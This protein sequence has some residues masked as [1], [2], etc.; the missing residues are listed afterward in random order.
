M[1]ST[2]PWQLHCDWLWDRCGSGNAPKEPRI[3]IAGCGTFEPYAFGLANPRA[4]ILATDISRRSLAIAQRRCQLHGVRNTRMAPCDLEHPETW[5]KGQF[6][7]IECYGVLMNLSDPE[8]TLRELGKRLTSRGVL[9]IMVYPWFSRARIFQIQR[10]ARLCG[11]HANDQSHPGQL[12]SLM[13]SLP[14]AHPLRWAF[15][16]YRDSRNDAGVVDAFLHA[17]DRGFTGWQLGSLIEGAGLQPAYWFHRPW[18]QPDQMADRLGLPQATQSLTLSYLDLWQEL[19][20][21]YVVCLRRQD[22]DPRQ[23]GTERP[24]PGFTSAHGSVRR[25]L[26]LKRLRLLGGRV[27]SRTD[28]GSVVLKASQARALA[29]NPNR[30]DEPTR[31]RLREAGLLLG[32]TDEPPRL[33]SHSDFAGQSEFLADTSALRVGR[34]APNPLYGHLF[35]AWELDRRHPELGLG[36]VDAQVKRWQPWADPLE[37]RPVQFGLTPYGTYQQCRQSIS[38][39]LEREDLPV[40]ESWAGV[41]LRD[42]A[43]K[44][45]QVRT[46]LA[47]RNLQPP[48]PGRAALREL[49]MLLWGHEQLFCRLMPA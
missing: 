46:L 32:G 42:D 28:E 21:N 36:D 26:S 25:A 49:W 34:Q 19:R 23:A 43:R 37:Q 22:A 20:Q 2:H 7:L 16:N 44:L 11:L 4:E 47:D 15:N 12:R 45:E 30:L 39:H 5:P 33:E 18:A 1:P 17:G 38:D 27:P 13:R 29:S 6:D 9:R 35:A 41:R 3:W 8:A 48:D 24:H 14:R 10:L 31:Q 40:A